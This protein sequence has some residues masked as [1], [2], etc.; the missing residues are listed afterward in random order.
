[1]FIQ[2]LLKE[3][4]TMSEEV[5]NTE[6]LNEE[7][8]ALE[9]STEPK[10]DEIA[11]GDKNFPELPPL[12]S[13]TDQLEMR[14]GA[15]CIDD[16]RKLQMALESGAY[17]VAEMEGFF[18]RLWNSF[19]NMFQGVY[20]F[21]KVTVE[22]YIALFKQ[23]WQEYAR[24]YIK[25]IY[26]NTPEAEQFSGTICLRGTRQQMEKNKACLTA[27]VNLIRNIGSELASKENTA[28]TRNMR[29]CAQYLEM[30]GCTVD[31]ARPSKCKAATRFTYGEFGRLGTMGYGSDPTV[32][33]AHMGK[34]LDV[35]GDFFKQF[36]D[37]NK[38]ASAVEQAE[39]AIA[40]EMKKMES[41][42]NPNARAA[43]GER[44]NNIKTRLTAFRA[45]MRA[46]FDLWDTTMMT[47][48]ILPVQNLGRNAGMKDDLTSWIL[49][50]KD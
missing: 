28:M 10:G 48:I 20:N 5:K 8:E 25:W 42:S 12:E 37:H 32:F 39:Q 13:G 41:T 21:L 14:L 26:D 23:D 35:W 22:S 2:L 50:T 34:N 40:N 44:I 38:I 29:N 49:A 18:E 27:V 16:W 6:S 33:L 36:T 46:G 9:P 43:V 47:H 3:E 17:P 19:T 4:F 1:M 7:A 31:L 30:N 15:I 24:R 11:E 45:I